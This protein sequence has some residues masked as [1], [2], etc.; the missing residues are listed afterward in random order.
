[1]IELTACPHCGDLGFRLP[2]RKRK[3]S[4]CGK[5]AYIRDGRPMSEQQAKKYDY[6]RDR[7]FKW[8]T[9]DE[10]IAYWRAHNLKQIREMRKSGLAFSAVRFRSVDGHC[11]YCWA[12]NKQ[13]LPLSNCQIE[14][15]PPF[16]G[17]TNERPC[18]VLVEVV[19]D[20]P[21]MRRMM[22]R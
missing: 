22:D 8:M 19:F 17:C 11:A 2:T 7:P 9:R 6:A 15:M 1:M 14:N 21:I 13:E 18:L 4:L 20:D 5:I 12:R 10:T 3:C 16:S